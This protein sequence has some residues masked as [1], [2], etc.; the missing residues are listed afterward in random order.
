MER[1]GNGKPRNPPFP[2]SF[3]SIPPPPPLP[4]APHFTRWQS[5]A[6][7]L[8]AYS[9]LMVP[10]TLFT[11]VHTLRLRSIM[12][13]GALRCSPKCTAA[14]GANSEKAEERNS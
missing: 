14:V 3:P 7:S 9:T 5:G 6:N 1:G 11:W 4:R 2:L 13:Y 12:L 10:P 8:M